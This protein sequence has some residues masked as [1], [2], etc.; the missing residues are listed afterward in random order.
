MGTFGAAHVFYYLLGVRF[1]DSSLSWY[2][3]FLDPELLKHNL[4]ESLFYLHGQPP[5]FNLFLGLVLKAAPTAGRYVFQAV[6]L[7][8]GATLY[9]SLF[10][11][12]R[13]LGVTPG[14]AFAVSTL[15][16][17]SPSFMLFEHLLFYTLPVAALVVLAALLFFE[18]A[19]RRR[20]WAAVA[21]FAVLFLICGTRH[22][23]HLVYYLLAAGA[24]VAFSA[25]NRKKILAAAAVPFLLLFSIYFKNYVVFGEFTASTWTGMQFMQ[26][27]G[28]FLPPEEMLSLQAE[29]KISPLATLPTFTD[30][31]FYPPSYS[32]VD[33][34]EDVPALA[35]AHKSTGP[36][37]FNH[38]AYI[39]IAKQYRKDSWTIFRYQPRTYLK[40]LTRSWF[41]YFKSSMDYA[42]SGVDFLDESGNVGRVAFVREVYDD[43]VYGKFYS[44]PLLMRVMALAG[45]PMRDCELC[46]YLIIGLPLLLFYGVRLASKRDAAAS[47]GLT[48]A[49]RLTLAFIC[50]TILYVA[51]AAGMLT[52]AESNR[53][54]FLS[55][56]LSAALA[57]VFVQ[58]FIV[59]SV[60]RSLQGGKGRV[61]GGEV[62]NEA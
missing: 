18:V 54:R 58:H 33:K 44:G 56:P 15:F 24:L 14:V 20:A 25:G 5:L 22:L 26:M 6:F 38:L 19:A 60:R 8:F 28:Y 37:N 52:W 43:A 32:K 3:Q 59:A 13:R 47:A 39:A 31:T 62:G 49:G 30:L 53:I 40:A 34:F 23:F 48:A 4:W 51:A 9:L 21:F 27:T 61:G 1:D 36:P 46:P 10:G 17:V 42:R 29:G 7:A 57:G 35:Q 11:L 50:F 55:D 12:Q 45:R 16:L 41:V 2:W